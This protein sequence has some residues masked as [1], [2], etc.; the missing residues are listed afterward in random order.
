MQKMESQPDCP[1]LV[2]GNARAGEDRSY[3]AASTNKRRIINISEIAA[4]VTKESQFKT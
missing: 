3:T 2:E 4:R 1:I